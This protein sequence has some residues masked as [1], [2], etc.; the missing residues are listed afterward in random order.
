MSSM[1]T[2]SAI[3]LHANLILASQARSGYV[4][5]DAHQLALEGLQSLGE[6]DYVRMVADLAATFVVQAQRACRQAGDLNL[7][8]IAAVRR[9]AGLAGGNFDVAL[10]AARESGAVVLHTHDG[11][12]GQ[13][14]AEEL[15]AVVVEGGRRFAYVAVRGD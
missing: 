9:A 15:A 11:R 3:G 7:A 14:S 8:S 1:S 2:K 6:R 4:A 13:L 10:F 12:H 5:A